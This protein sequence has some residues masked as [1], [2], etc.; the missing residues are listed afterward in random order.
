MAHPKTVLK[1]ANWAPEV[2]VFYFVDLGIKAL[3]SFGPI[4][5]GYFWWLL[6]RLVGPTHRTHLSSARGGG[7]PGVLPL[8]FPSILGCQVSKFLSKN[9]DQLD[10]TPRFQ[11]FDKSSGGRMHSKVA[12]QNLLIFPSTQKK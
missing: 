12:V 4:V 5:V 9:L 8:F 7:T 11:Y 10:Q 3:V 2:A 1:R 6:V